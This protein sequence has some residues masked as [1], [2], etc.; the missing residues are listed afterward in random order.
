M[1]T[2][3]HQMSRGIVTF[4]KYLVGIGGPRREVSV[5]GCDALKDVTH[6]VRERNAADR[7]HH[8]P[9]SVLRGLHTAQNDCC[10]RGE[11]QAKNMTN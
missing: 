1:L 10:R 4:M 9:D 3:S 5:W 2:V 8:F 6:I 7:Q 11:Q